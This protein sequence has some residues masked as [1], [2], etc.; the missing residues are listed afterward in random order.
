MSEENVELVLQ[1]FRLVEANEFERWTDLW[2]PDSE[3]T[4]PGG[5][6][7]QGPFTG[8]DAVVRQFERLTS[9]WEEHHFEDVELAA[10][11]GEW[12]VFTFSWHARG[13]AS[14]ID[15]AFQMAVANRV[16]DGK[17]A[18]AHFRW[19]RQEA[20]EAAGLEE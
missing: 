17:L 7:E 9:D 13:V 14:G 16:V 12:V 8:R 2:H 18:E 1:G 20:L 10:D 15:T 19:N 5:W 3:A 6:P 4:A 11:S